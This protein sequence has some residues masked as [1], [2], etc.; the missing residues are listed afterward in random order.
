MLRPVD[1]AAA[2]AGAGIPAPGRVRTAADVPELHLAWLAARSARWLV[3]GDGRAVGTYP[4]DSPAESKDTVVAPGTDETDTDASLLNT[5][6]TAFEEVC[7]TQSRDRHRTGVLLACHLLLSILTEQPSLRHDEADKRLRDRLYGLDW[8][9]GS[10]ALDPFSDR[11]GR[12]DGVLRLLESFAAVDSRAGRVALT[13]L[14]RWLHEVV[15]ASQVTPSLPAAELVARLVATDNSEEV[16]VLLAQWAGERDSIGMFTELLR[17]AADAGP[18]ARDVMVE[19][20]AGHGPEMMPALIAVR[21]LPTLAAHAADVLFS[22]GLGDEPDATQTR[23]LLTEFMLAVLHR[24]GAQ[25]V[26]DEV[27]TAGGLTSVVGGGHPNEPELRE[28]IDA[29]LEAGGRPRVLRLKV[30]LNAWRPRPW[31]RVRIPAA[32]SLGDLHLVIQILFDWDGDHLHAFTTENGLRFGDL[33]E[34]EDEHNARLYRAL[35]RA[36]SRL[37]YLYDFGA[38]WKHTVTLE[39]V[40]FYEAA[41]AVEGKPPRP[42]CS[43]GKGDAPVEYWDP[44]D[45]EPGSVPFD[46]EEINKRLAAL[47]GQEG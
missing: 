1:V 16:D 17:A 3:I 19:A 29:I 32:A 47:A 27:A 7:R 18:A 45:S 11:V 28:A 30:E 37:D 9:S 31:R 12:F 44:E 36:G 41:D 43:D 35:P 38:S 25:A 26:L 24:H 46:S 5:W 14:G 10:L 33:D 39:A 34:A 21:D 2:A 13:P 4:A 42:V 23:W 22:N 8:R 6:A 20:V 40:D 15:R